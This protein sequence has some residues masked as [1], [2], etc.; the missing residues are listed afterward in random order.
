MAVDQSPRKLFDCTWVR[1]HD[2]WIKDTLQVCR[3]ANCATGPGEYACMYVHIYMCPCSSVCVPERAC[4][5]VGDGWTDG[6]TEDGD[7]GEF[8]CVHVCAC[9]RDPACVRVTVGARM[10]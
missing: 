2:P 3:A 1:Y 8:K 9:V 7:L 10:Q 6:R 4:L 5:Y